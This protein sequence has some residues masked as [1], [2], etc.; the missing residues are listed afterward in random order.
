MIVPIPKTKLFLKGEETK[1][2]H[3][4]V[5]SQRGEP[6]LRTESA[7]TCPRCTFP[8]PT[9]VDR[10]PY[11]AAKRIMNLEISLN[12]EPILSCRPMNQ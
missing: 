4:L 7:V 1:P 9:D 5:T 12:F 11:R 8:G 3:W 10:I 6:D 2:S